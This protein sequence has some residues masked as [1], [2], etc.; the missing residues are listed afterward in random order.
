[1]SRPRPSLSIDLNADLGESYGAYSLGADE[2]MLGIV[3][4]ANIACGFHAGDPKV[5][6][7]TV[8][9]AVQRG[10]RVGAHPGYRDLAGFG[11]RNIAYNPDDLY[12]E[13]IYQI[14]AITAAAAA[15]GTEIS[16]VKPHG[17]MYNTIATDK[18]LAEAVISAVRDINPALKLMCLAGAPIVDWA[19]DGGLAVI[20]E[21]F[22][23]RAYTENGQLA[24]RSLPGAVHLDPS[25]A[26]AQ[27]VAIAT[28]D[29]I[30]TIDGSSITIEADSLCVHG[31]NPH[32]V[33]LATRIRA[34]LQ[35]QGV[36]VAA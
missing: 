25:I 27:A 14:G 13:V 16:Y 21:A 36:E 19:V 12:A 23:D 34:T 3:T 28:G 10:I 7:D 20:R 18:P 6:F 4:S 5:L 30:P 8:A 22:A 2:H 17:A 24:A 1:M 9:K 35:E 31:D 15:N 11:R 33:A 32:A 26:T 29:P